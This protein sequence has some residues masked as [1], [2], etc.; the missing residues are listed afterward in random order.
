MG[1]LLVD[2]RHDLGFT[3]IASA[4]DVDA[5]TVEAEFRKMEDEARD[6]LEHEGV[7]PRNMVLT[8][9]IDMMYRGQWRTLN[10]Q[11][12]APFKSV[13]Q[14]VE[15]FHINHDREYNFRRDDTPVD[16]FRLNLSAIGQSPKAGLAKHKPRRGTPKPIGKRP[17]LFDERAKP[18]ST[19]VYAR[20][21]LFAGATIDGPAVI[22][23][24]DSTTLV[25]PGLVA[26][27][28]P[29]LNLIIK[30]SEAKR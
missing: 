30:V 24:L 13:R 18:A 9:S 27:V 2:I 26:K 4:D 16:L 7:K 17:V 22:E 25:P 1:C 23:Q 29:W 19:P 10:V 12:P 28:D 15:A 8:R 3:Y 21:D 14:A 20:H 5:K 6:R 11:V